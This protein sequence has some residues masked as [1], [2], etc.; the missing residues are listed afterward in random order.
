MLL[1]TFF[2]N[3]YL[4]IFNFSFYLFIFIYIWSFFL[5][6][7]DLRRKFLSFLFVIILFSILGFLF[8]LDGIFLI[9]LTAEF[10]I[11][12]ILIMTFTQLY[13]NYSFLVNNCYKFIFI[14]IL[15]IPLL[16]SIDSSFYLFQSYYSSTVSIISSDFYILFYFLFEQFPLITILVILIISFFSLFFIL[17]YFSLKLVKSFSYK[18]FKTNYWLRKQILTKQVN[19][20]SKLYTFQN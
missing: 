18:N 7:T 16:Y 8:N 3:L 17:M 15:F 1:K 10:T 20:K 2:F 12:L 6:F 11:F 4:V 19:F 13:S 5:L 14:F 9:F